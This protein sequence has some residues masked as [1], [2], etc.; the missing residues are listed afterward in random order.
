MSIEKFTGKAEAY[1]SARPSYPEAAVDYITSLATPNA[2]FTDVGAGTGKFSELI[3]KRGYTLFAVEPNADMQK[4]LAIT[5]SPYPNAKP[6]VG[7]AE[8]TALSS[9]S[10]DIITCAQ[11]LHWIDPAAFWEECKRIGKP[12]SIVVALY[13]IS[14]GGN[15]TANFNRSTKAF[16]KN[17]TVKEF[18]NPIYFTREKWLAYMTSHSG[19]PLPSDPNYAEHMAQ[20][21]AIFD[22]E[23]VD[24]LLKRDV[25]T[26]VCSEYIKRGKLS[27]M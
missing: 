23:S 27:V 13:N 14:C 22:S 8:Q 2:V 21:N 17:P 11:A 5:L 10:V 16:F 19:A 26:K 12:D 7:T 25:V 15:S 1:A 9:N 3:A 6:V 20:V 24:G 4:Q 18:P